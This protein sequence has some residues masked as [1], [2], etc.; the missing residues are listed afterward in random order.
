MNLV[1]CPSAQHAAGPPTKTVD[2]TDTYSGVTYK[3]PYRWLEN[4]KHEA[5]S[6][7]FKA[8]AKLTDDLLA[9]IP[10]RDA[11]ADEWMALDRLQPARYGDILLENGGVFYKKTLGG[12]N[13]GKQAQRPTEVIQRLARHAPTRD[14]MKRPLLTPSSDTRGAQ[15]LTSG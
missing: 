12:E 3:D 8:Q 6:Q 9:R 2:A 11:L 14:D 10:A 5:A 13:V 1:K 7:W 4:L 15:A